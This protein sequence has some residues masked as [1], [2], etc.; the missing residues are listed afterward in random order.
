[1]GVIPFWGS[2][3]L[4]VPIEPLV[5]VLAAFGFEDLRRRIVPR[6]RGL[7]LVRGRAAR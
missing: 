5:V 2:L 1:V 3:R 7:G 4:R 6:V